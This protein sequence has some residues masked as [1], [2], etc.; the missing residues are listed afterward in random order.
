MLP[1]PG[2]RKDMEHMECPC[3]T[4]VFIERELDRRKTSM[5]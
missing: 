5:V 4:G 2:A 1:W 3:R